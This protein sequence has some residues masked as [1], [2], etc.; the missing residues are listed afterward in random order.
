MPTAP[1]S[2]G[3]APHGGRIHLHSEFSVSSVNR[4]RLIQLLLDLVVIDSHSKEERQVADFLIDYCRARGAEVEEDGA[5]EQVGGNAGNLFV[6]FKGNK[7]DAQPIFLSAHMDTVVPGKGVKPRREGNRITTDGTTVLGGDDKS[8]IAAILEA[9]EVIRENDSPHGD[10]EIV[11]TIC[12]EMGL[13]GAKHFDV[14]KLTAKHGLVLDSDDVGFLFTRAPS[15]DRMEFRVRGQESHAGMFPERGINAIKVA[16]D[17]IANMR[18]G[19][20]DHET[21]ANIGIVRGGE[22]VNIVPNEVVL[23]GEARSLDPAK[24]DAQTAHMKACLEEAAAKYSVELNG[25]RVAARVE[26]YIERDYDRMNVPDDSRIVQLVFKA[27]HGL[28]QT[29]RTQAF[30]GGCDANVFN[31][32]GLTVAN[33]GTGMREIHTVHEWIDLD[34]F[35]RCARVVAE[36]IRL[37]AVID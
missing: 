7:P 37:N 13:V 3:P 35:E 6:R 34:E 23:E 27:A 19:R 12:E 15:A 30:G 25:H 9:I 14:S 4:E 5:G 16:A 20:I 33:L 1:S 10:I 17:G 31:G 21:T 36:V 18:L 32:K 26:S 11:F 24:L 22:A 28:G 2:R 8:G 29:V